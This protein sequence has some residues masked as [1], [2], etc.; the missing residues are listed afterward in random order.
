MRT[1][2]GEM[3]SAG[4]A[5]ALLVIMFAFAWYGVDRTPGGAVSTEDAW[6]ALPVVRWIM[7]LSIAAALASAT[8]P[9]L[10]HRLGAQT[11]AAAVTALGGLTAVL[12]VVRVLIALPSPQAVPDQKLGALL[13]ML[14]ALGIALGG[15]EALRS[16]RRRRVPRR[17]GRL[18]TRCD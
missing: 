13:G 9:W 16:A 7:L 1:R 3:A 5:L 8:L 4:C 10:R 12:L 17:R 14:S 18:A 6:S 2:R 15:W 11:R